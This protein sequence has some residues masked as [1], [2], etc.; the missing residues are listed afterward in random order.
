MRKDI[1]TDGGTDKCEE[2]HNFAKAPKN[3]PTKNL[4]TQGRR[5]VPLR[6]RDQNKMERLWSTKQ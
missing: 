6:H 3:V 4:K 1:Q 2:S 5:K